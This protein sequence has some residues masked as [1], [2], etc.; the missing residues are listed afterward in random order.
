M[1]HTVRFF[2]KISDITGEPLIQVPYS[3]NLDEIMKSLRAKYP[4]LKNQSYL[5][6][7]NKQVRIKEAHLN[8]GDEIAL[9]P[10]FSGG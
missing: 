10:P 4:G 8:P 7:V 3:G 6:T 5:V 1:S 2:G 9:L